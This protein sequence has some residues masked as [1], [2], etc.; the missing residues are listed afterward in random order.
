MITFSRLALA[1]ICL[2]SFGLTPVAAEV[3]Y[4]TRAIHIARLIQ[5]SRR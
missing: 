4:P 2:S 5:D 1:A 3:K